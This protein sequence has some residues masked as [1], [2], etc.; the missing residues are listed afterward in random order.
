MFDFTPTSYQKI[1]SLRDAQI[2]EAIEKEL[3]ARLQNFLEA[4]QNSGVAQPKIAAYRTFCTKTYSELL[5]EIDVV[6]TKKRHNHEIMMS[7]RKISVLDD[8]KDEVYTQQIDGILGK[9]SMKQQSLNV[10]GETCALQ[11][12]YL[13]TLCGGK[14]L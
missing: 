6:N 7:A 9:S 8:K 5:E 12:A 13:G 10:E 4:T 2:K 14:F 11:L 1:S 3:N